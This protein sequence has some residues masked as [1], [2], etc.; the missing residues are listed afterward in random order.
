VGKVHRRNRSGADKVINRTLRK[1]ALALD[2]EHRRQIVVLEQPPEGPAQVE[3][4]MGSIVNLAHVR[5][6]VQGLLVSGPTQGRQVLREQLHR[7]ASTVTQQLVAEPW[8]HHAARETMTRTLNLLNE[9]DAAL[10]VIKQG[11]PATTATQIMVPS[12]V[13]Y[14]AHHTLF[15]AERMLV[16]AGRRQGETTTL[17]A[18]FEVTGASSG[19][20]VRAD[21]ERLGRALIAMD[22]SGTY[23]AAWFH[24]HPGTGPRATSPSAIDLDQH[25]DWIRDYTPNLLSG[26]FVADRWIRFWGTALRQS[27][28]RVLVAGR[29]VAEEDRDGHLYRLVD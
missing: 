6:A 12:D 7:M 26:V 3:A 8:D 13:F 17:G 16:V 5:T 20:H 18:V 15:P 4:L 28:I 9:A 11:Q 22:R 21:P 1:L 25:Q 29:G 27:Q 14:Q 24:S 10:A 2:A 19:D 23:L